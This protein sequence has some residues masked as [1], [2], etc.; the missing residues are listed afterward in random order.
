[1]ATNKQRLLA[2]T[3][4]AAAA[5]LGLT[6][7]TVTNNKIIWQYLG[8]VGTPTYGKLPYDTDDGEPKHSAYTT[9]LS[10]LPIPDLPTSL[11]SRIGVMLPEGSNISNNTRVSLGSDEQTNL[12]LKAGIESDIYVSFLAEGAGYRNSVGYFT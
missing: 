11:L 7:Y 9:N 10:S 3:A 5:T 2:V 12:V 8:Q 4:L 6:G 1:M